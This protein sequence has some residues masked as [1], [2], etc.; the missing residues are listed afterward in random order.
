MRPVTSTAMVDAVSG[1]WEVLQPD[2]D[3]DRP[4]AMTF[5]D[6]SASAMRAWTDLLATD[7][8][9]AAVQQF[10]E[11][12]PSMIPGGSGDIGPGGHHGS[13]FDA[14]FKLPELKGAGPSFRPDFMW[15]TR[16]TACI[17]P[18]LIEIE[19]PTKRWFQKSGRPT[20]D[21]TAAHD[22]LND[23]RSWFKRDANLGVFRDRYLFLSDYARRPIEPYFLLIYGRRSEFEM[24]GVHAHPDRL[25][26]KRDAGRRSDETFMTFDSLRPHYH[27]SN[28]ITVTMTTAGPEPYAFS[29]V[30]G[31]GTHVIE[32]GRLLG[33][34]VAALERSV[35]MTSARKQYLSRRWG[36]WREVANE[37]DEGRRRGSGPRGIGLE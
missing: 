16:S 31:T 22:Q 12:H 35:M 13:E 11:L 8:D 6:Y 4:H 23:W 2:A 15:V 9:E 1:G 30:Y 37:I 19:R 27:H 24:G 32:S 7:P 20:A 26:H 18:I 10:L 3:P 28:S 33:D 25:L 21:F 14:V 29:P 17:T 5:L 34:P 36:H